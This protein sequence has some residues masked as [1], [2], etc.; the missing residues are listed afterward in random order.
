MWFD[1]CIGNGCDMW[2]KCILNCLGD[3]RSSKWPITHCDVDLCSILLRFVEFR[4]LGNLNHVLFLRAV[5]MLLGLPF[6]SVGWSGTEFCLDSVEW[7]SGIPFGALVRWVVQN[8]LFQRCSLQLNC[9][10]L[11]LR[12]DMLYVLLMMWWLTLLIDVIM[13]WRWIWVWLS[14][15]F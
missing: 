4:E 7:W 8:P 6:N 9:V 2:L 11:A 14:W 12:F 1:L 15:V 3:V 10:A 5:V 13:E